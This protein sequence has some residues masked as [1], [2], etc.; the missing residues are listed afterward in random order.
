MKSDQNKFL[1]KSDDFVAARVGDDI[2]PFLG[3]EE[4][5]STLSICNC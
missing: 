5:S 3:K 2:V 1:L 4:S